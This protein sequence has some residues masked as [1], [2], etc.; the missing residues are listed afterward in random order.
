MVEMEADVS[1]EL[2]AM[3]SHIYVMS[4]DHELK[5]IEKGQSRGRQSWL[6]DLSQWHGRHTGA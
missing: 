2:V 5:C 1:Q 3:L 6:W 4:R